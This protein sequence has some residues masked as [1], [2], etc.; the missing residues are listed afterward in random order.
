[1]GNFA[2]I[3]LTGVTHVFVEKLEQLSQNYPQNP[4]L[5]ATLGPVVQN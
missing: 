4:A 3:V 5:F 2:K 1:M